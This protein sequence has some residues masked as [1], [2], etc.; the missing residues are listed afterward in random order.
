VTKMAEV[1]GMVLPWKRSV[2]RS[3]DAWWS[4]CKVH[5]EVGTTRCRLY[6]LVNA[7][8]DGDFWFQGVGPVRIYG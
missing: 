1:D 8:V 7:G 6:I 4:F 2:Y 5:R 3:V